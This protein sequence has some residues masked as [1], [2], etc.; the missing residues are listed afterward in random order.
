MSDTME[1]SKMSLDTEIA[2]YESKL[3]EFEQY[4]INKF[5]VIH[6]SEFIGAFDT[7][8]NAAIEAVRRFGRGPYLIRKVGGP[9]PSIPLSW[10]YQPA[11]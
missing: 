5:V 6:G 2:F 4:Y 9:P 3:G 7:F 11:A 1:R 8:E 10:L